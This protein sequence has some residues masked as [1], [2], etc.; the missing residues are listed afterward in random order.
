MAR[1]EAPRHNLRR[2]TIAFTREIS[3]SVADCEL[4][5]LEREPIDLTRARAQHARYEETL[6]ELGCTVER[7]P[8]LPDLPDAV[9]VE[10]TAVVLP[11]VAIITR[12]GAASRRPEVA[13]VADALG[14][15]RGLE[16]IEDAGTLDGGDV[17][18]IGSTIYVGSSSRTNPDGIEQLARIAKLHG[19]ALQPVTVS[20]CLHL[21]SAVTQVGEDVVLL[22]PDWVNPATFEHLR[23][24][25]VAAGE[26]FAAN[27][28]LVGG[29]VVYPT[30][31]DRT[32]HRLEDLGIDV[33][34]VDTGELQKAE[35]GVTCCAILVEA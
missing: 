18:V 22:N 24:I 6:A 15:Y 27:A 31:F 10:D 4:T 33:H 12:P 28:L 35:G 3:R 25:A 13:S 2:M 34:A 32:R 8:P 14:K 20:G 1:F 11:E 26:P 7:L 19:Y 17:L 9:F 16:F 21:K 5:H 23:C 30:G 29:S